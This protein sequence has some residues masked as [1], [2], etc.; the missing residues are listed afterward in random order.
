MKI[1][2]EIDT[3]DSV[4]MGFR[5]AGATE[6]TYKLFCVNLLRGVL[7]RV[8]GLD[9]VEIDAFP[10]VK[11]ESPLVL[12]LKRLVESEGNG[13]KLVWGPLRGW[14]DEKEGTA[15]VGKTGLEGLMGGLGLGSE[16]VAR[17]V[18]VQA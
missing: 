17:V 9:T 11:R 10:G 14:E 8:P 2:V 16:A 3:S 13:V 7:A 15:S 12:A 1:M 6:D 5:G 4:F 18:E